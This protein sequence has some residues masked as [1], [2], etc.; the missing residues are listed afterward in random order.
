M[1][2]DGTVISQIKPGEDQ[3]VER[4]RKAVILIALVTDLNVICQ[5]SSVATKSTFQVFFFN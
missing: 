3:K 2:E 4:G 5:C 1:R